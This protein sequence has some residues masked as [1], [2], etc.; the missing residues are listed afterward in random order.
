[1]RLT[2]QS[3]P[4]G[5]CAAARAAHAGARGFTI[6]ET[7]VAMLIMLIAGLSATSLFV[8]SMRNN[9][10]AGS[11]LAALALAQQRMERLR[12]VP[13]DDASLAAGTTSDTV[14]VTD[15]VYTVQTTVCADSTCGASDTIKRITLQVTPYNSITSDHGTNSAITLTAERAALATGPYLQ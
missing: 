9:T 12:N 11:R 10:L 5:K 1:M 3:H 4:N 8:Y 13:F 6:I 15:S 14:T 2:R 7:V